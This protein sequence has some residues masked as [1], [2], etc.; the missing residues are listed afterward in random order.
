MEPIKKAHRI[1]SNSDSKDSPLNSKTNS[2][3]RPASTILQ[4]GNLR[5][6][7]KPM[8]KCPSSSTTANKNAIDARAVLCEEEVVSAHCGVRAIWVAPSCR[9]QG[10]A[11]RLL[12]AARLVPSCSCYILEMP[13][14]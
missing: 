1:I 4:F 2:F 8:K 10:V 6:E 7:R 9:N 12:D 14:F 13:I 5:F 11:T 3:A